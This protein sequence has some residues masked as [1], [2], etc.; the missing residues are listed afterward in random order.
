MGNFFVI[1]GTDDMKDTIDSLNVGEKGIT[2]TC[3]FGCTLDQTSNIDEM[4][5]GRILGRRI[6]DG[7]KFFVS[8]VRNGA[9]RGVGVNRAEG[10]VFSIGLG[11]LTEEVEKRLGNQCEIHNIYIII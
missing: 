3:S 2:K 5:K 9:S 10:V 8:F 11:G 6:P 1:K 7:A 4:K